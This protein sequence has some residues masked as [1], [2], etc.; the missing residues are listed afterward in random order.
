MSNAK[1]CDK[2]GKVIP[3]GEEKDALS[4]APDYF[5]AIRGTTIVEFQDLC[6]TCMTRV[7]LNSDKY[8][9]VKTRVSKTVE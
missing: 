8:I 5:A 2:C 6:P 3:E 9:N 4:S 7:T 1:V